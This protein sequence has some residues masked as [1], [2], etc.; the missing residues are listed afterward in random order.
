L[1][2]AYG[3]LAEQ[4]EEASDAGLMHSLRDPLD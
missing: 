2:E 3:R 1:A 4:A